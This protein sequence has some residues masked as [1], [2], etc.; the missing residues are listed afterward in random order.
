MFEK[1]ALFTQNSPLLSA[2]KSWLLYSAAWADGG[3]CSITNISIEQ[4][5]RHTDG[6]R[7]VDVFSVMQNVQYLT[8]VKMLQ[9]KII[10]VHVVH[11]IQE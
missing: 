10:L 5:C 11:E 7:T 2:T 4:I 8:P 6:E 1:V 3:I 9:T